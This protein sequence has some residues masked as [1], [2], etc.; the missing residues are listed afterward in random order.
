MTTT[1][2][3]IGNGCTLDSTTE[4]RM[5]SAP[6][7]IAQNN[8]CPRNASTLRPLPD[9]RSRSSMVDE[10]PSTRPSSDR[11]RVNAGPNT[12]CCVA[13]IVLAS[14]TPLV[15]CPLGATISVTLRCP[16]RASSQCTTMSTD[17]ATVGTTNDASILRPASSGRV[18]SLAS[19]SLALLAWML[20][21]PGSP[22][23]G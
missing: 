8:C 12:P 17:A 4:L 20:H 14:M 1:C 6:P 13:K 19:A 9:W 3:A 15:T 18:Q 7:T 22:V 2:S 10:P 11:V 5:P 21:M 23:F 16:L